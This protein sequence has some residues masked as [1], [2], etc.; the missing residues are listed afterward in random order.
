M[1][2]PIKYSVYS[3]SGGFLMICPLAVL[4][5]VFS[6]TSKSVARI[7]RDTVELDGQSIVAIGYSHLEFQ[8]WGPITVRRLPVEIPRQAG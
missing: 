4:A 8:S 7:E 3:D 2:S 6:L 1:D 5:R